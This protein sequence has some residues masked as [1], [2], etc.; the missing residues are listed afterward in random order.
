MI[1]KALLVCLGNICRS[2]MAE[3]LLKVALPNIQISSA[4]LTAMVGYGAD[5][6][7]VEIMAERGIDISSHRARMLTESIIRD[8]DLI[9]VMDTMQKQHILTQYPYVL[10]KVFRLGEVDIP[11]PFQNGQEKFNEVFSTIEFAV[12]EWSRRIHSIA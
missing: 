12:G 2:P 7:A 1:R 3:G 8:A 10:G 9:L 4:G 11:D 5:P 6:I